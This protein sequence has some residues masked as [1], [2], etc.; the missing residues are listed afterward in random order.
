MQSEENERHFYED[1][2]SL[3]ATRI[4]SQV[5]RDCPLELFLQSLF[6]SPTIAEIAAVITEHQE[7]KVEEKELD[8]ILNELESLTDD[9]DRQ[10]LADGSGATPIKFKNEDYYQ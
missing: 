6:A 4:V 8:Q 3:A 7:N 2:H 5:I 1:H 9:E 10:L